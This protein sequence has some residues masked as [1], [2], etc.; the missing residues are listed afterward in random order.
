MA[1]F[2]DEFASIRGVSEIGFVVAEEVGDGF[3]R[4]EG[5]GGVDVNRHGLLTEGR[6]RK[7][8]AG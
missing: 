4:T 5:G 6:G 7:E 8:T 1:E 3:V 2:V